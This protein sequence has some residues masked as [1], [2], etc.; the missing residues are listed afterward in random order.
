MHAVTNIL[1]YVKFFLM[2]SIQVSNYDASYA[3]NRHEDNQQQG[4]GGG[5]SSL[6]VAVQDLYSSMEIN[7][8]PPEECKFH[9]WMQ[10]CVQYICRNF[11]ICH[12]YSQWRFCG[13]TI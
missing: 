4:A 9:R 6:D 8:V 10:I 7:V 1:L 13:G 3:Q 5:E 12:I 11:P 2:I